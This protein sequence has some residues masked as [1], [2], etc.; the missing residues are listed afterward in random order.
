MNKK[1]Q[2]LEKSQELINSETFK[3]Q[4]RTSEKYF[5]RM[6][7]LCFSVLIILI[8]RKSVKCDYFNE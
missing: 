2:L 3:E 4:H 5:T 1:K 6:R 8:I 7:K